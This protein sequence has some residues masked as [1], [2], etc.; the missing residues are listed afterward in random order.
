MA[1]LPES[2]DFLH[3][4]IFLRRCKNKVLIMSWR[5]DSAYFIFALMRWCL[6]VVLGLGQSSLS[7][8]CTGGGLFSTTSTA[9][10][11]GLGGLGGIDPKTVGSSSSGG[12]NKVW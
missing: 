2:Q 11:S 3:L 5:R 8:A 10:T 1:S 7:V 4:N 9:M 12:T 6:A